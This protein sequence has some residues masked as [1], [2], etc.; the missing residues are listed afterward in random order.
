MDLIIRQ[1]TYIY[2][3]LSTFL[4]KV[5]KT[6]LFDFRKVTVIDVH[7]SRGAGR[8]NSQRGSSVNNFMLDKR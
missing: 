8:I 2:T 4:A 5:V 7:Q 6:A 1:I 3:N